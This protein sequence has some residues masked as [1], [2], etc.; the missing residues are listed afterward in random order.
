MGVKTK[1]LLGIE[2]KWLGGQGSLESGVK[3]GGF[4]SKVEQVIIQYTPDAEYYINASFNYK[5]YFY[6]YLTFSSEKNSFF[7]SQ[8]KV[9]VSKIDNG[10]GYLE[11]INKRNEKVIGWVEM[12]DLIVI[13]K[14]NVDSTALQS[15]NSDI[16][17]N[18]SEI[19]KERKEIIIKHIEAEDYRY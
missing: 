16:Q 14:S 6:N 4:S 10:F 11:F 9:H 3:V 17:S 8:E 13:G 1:W 2:L 15:N 18:W 7:E 19:E 5:I 12:K